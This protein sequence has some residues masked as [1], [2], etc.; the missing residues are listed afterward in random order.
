MT[1]SNPQ[2]TQTT[3]EPQEE[4]IVSTE[5]PVTETAETQTEVTEETQ[6]TEET[7]EVQEEAVADPAKEEETSVPEEQEVD[8]TD[9]MNLTDEEFDKIDNPQYASNVVKMPE[10]EKETTTETAEDKPAE[11]GNKEPAKEPAKDTTTTTETKK[12]AEEIDYKAEYEKMISKFTANGQDFN[13]SN[14]EQAKQLMRKGA[15]YEFKM[16]QLSKHRGLISTIEQNKITDEDI[17][18]L[19]ELK[20]KK[21]EAVARMVKDSG[22][23]PLDLND[24]ENAE[25]YKAADYQVSGKIVELQEVVASVRTTEPGNQVM[26]DISALWDDESKKILLEQPENI[27]TRLVAD[28]QSGLYDKVM[29]KLNNDRILGNLRGVEYITAYAN[30]AGEMSGTQGNPSPQTAG[31]PQT[32]TAQGGTTTV[33]VTSAPSPKDAATKLANTDKAKAA[34]PTT[35][36]PVA[37]K[38]AVTDFMNMSDEEFDKLDAQ[39]MK[40]R[41]QSA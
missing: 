9:Y 40:G 22:I 24:I 31:T 21:P 20:N 36:T 29:L 4:A 15:N 11:E 16:N 18:M 3:Q 32:Q 1:E 28:K 7:Q 23:E 25:T 27:L 12:P 33:P 38:I 37:P 17:N 2:E 39:I 5:Q 19:I 8:N 13:V 10:K 34:S 14:A 30:L 35:K 26:D 41:Y 6:G